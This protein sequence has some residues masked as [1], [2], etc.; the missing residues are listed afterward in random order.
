MKAHWTHPEYENRDQLNSFYYLGPVGAYLAAELCIGLFAN[1]SVLSDLHSLGSIRSL[2]STLS[3]RNELAVH[4]I[5]QAALI[6]VVFT[7]LVTSMWKNKQETTL[8]HA[9]TG[10]FLA[11]LMAFLMVSP[12][13]DGPD[14]D[15]PRLQIV[16]AL[17]DRWNFPYAALEALFAFCFS[18]GLAIFAAWL[19]SSTYRLW[20]RVV[21]LL[22]TRRDPWS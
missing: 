9:L 3:R 6:P 2:A 21:F 14:H 10:T 1:L 7:L 13:K 8:K 5:T 20:V 19:A 11:S 16:S 15:T 17:V 12:S 4:F 22:R 18:L